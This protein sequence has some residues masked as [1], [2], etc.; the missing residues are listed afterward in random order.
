MPNA[1]LTSNLTKGL[2]I[3]LLGGSFNPPHAG[4]VHISRVA[5][6][7]L[8]LD[9]VYWLVSPRNP[10]KNS[11][12]LASFDSRFNA[13]LDIT[14]HD[15]KLVVSDYERN[16]GYNRTFE[17]LQALKARTPHTNYVWITGMDNAHNFHHWH[18]WKEIL[19]EV[20]IAH[21]ARPPALRLSQNCPARMLHTQDHILLHHASR[22]P[23][24]PRKTYWIIQ[25]KMVDISSSNIRNGIIKQ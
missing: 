25:K 15:P 23:L 8:K 1:L 6:H 3:G 10:L 13:C 17:T 2:R 22:V 21:I 5:L 14:R 16:I 7:M 20:A 18:R 12:N 4:H 19:D 9:M 11:N 24:I